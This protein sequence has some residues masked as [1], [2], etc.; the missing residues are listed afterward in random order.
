MSKQLLNE[1]EFELVNIV[2]AQLAQNQRD[3]SK[4]MNMSLGM[5][6]LLLKRLVTKGYIR[7][8]QLNSR[9]VQYLLTPKGF[10]EKMRKSIKYT[11]KTIN[12]ISLIKEHLKSILMS[13]YQQGHRQFIVVGKS[14]MAYLID[15]VFQ[16]RQ[17]QDVKV[18]HCDEYQPYALS[19]S[20]VLLCKEDLMPSPGQAHHLN[21][22]HELAK[23]DNSM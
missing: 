6:N 17:I 16:E 3:F 23:I 20:I 10:S 2:G 19:Q 8:K 13:F 11:L 21:L 22:I 5:T 1:R 12:S 9:K 18:E 15:A 4:Q 7:I 14:D